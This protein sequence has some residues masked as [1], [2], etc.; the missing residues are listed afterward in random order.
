MSAIIRPMRMPLARICRA[1]APHRLGVVGDALEELR[2]GED[3]VQR[4][5]QVVAE[6][7]GEHL[8]QPQRLGALAQL[9]RPA[10]CFWRC[11]SK[12]TS[13]LAAAGRAASIGL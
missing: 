13:R 12:N 6:H 10:S 11:S 8:V 5:A 4:R 9:A 2:R 7:R 3:D 1:D